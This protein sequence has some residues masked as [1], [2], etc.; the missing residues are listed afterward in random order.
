MSNIILGNYFTVPHDIVKGMDTK[1]NDYYPLSFFKNSALKLYVTLWHLAN[2]YSSNKF[3][4]GDEELGLL[5]GLSKRQ[6]CRTRKLL[7]H[8]GLITTSKR[9]GLKLDYEIVVMPY[10]AQCKPVLPNKA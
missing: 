2:R 8:M 4:A 7:F 5:T 6:L 10:L 1:G 3:Y 9:V